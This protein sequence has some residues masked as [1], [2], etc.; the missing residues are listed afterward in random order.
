MF[1]LAGGGLLY[2]QTAPVVF[3]LQRRHF[4]RGR[5][6]PEHCED[7]SKLKYYTDIDRIHALQLIA[8]RYDR[9]SNQRSYELNLVLT[10]GSRLNVIDHGGLD[11]IRADAQKLAAFLGKPL[12]DAI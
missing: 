5:K 12:W 3:D 9:S 4:V 7:L 8:E 2:S 10:D 11:V 1:S 6:S